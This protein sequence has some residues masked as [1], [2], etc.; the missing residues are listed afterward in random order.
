MTYGLRGIPLSKSID[1]PGLSR[2]FASKR[3]TVQSAALASSM[4]LISPEVSTFYYFLRDGSES[5][6]IVLSFISSSVVSLSLALPNYGISN[7]NSGCGTIS[8]YAMLCSSKDRLNSLTA[9]CDRSNLQ[10]VVD[11]FASIQHF[12]NAILRIIFVSFSH[13][14]VA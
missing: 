8:R 11:I 4:M 14:A 6:L 5:P 10:V 2:G 9:L 12:Q 3:G 7:N 1:T 13:L